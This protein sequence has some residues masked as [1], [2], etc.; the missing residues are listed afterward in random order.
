MPGGRNPRCNLSSPSGVWNGGEVEGRHATVEELGVLYEQC[1]DR[2]AGQLYAFT[3]DWQGSL[4]LV[5]EA[6]VRTWE[7]WDRVGGYDNPEAFVRRVAFN[8]AK[9]HWRRFRRTVLQSSTPEREGPVTDPESHHDLVAAL[10][11]LP[12]KER[13]AVVLHYLA[14]EPVGQ[15][16]GEMGVPEGTVKSWLSRARA[17]LAERLAA[18]DTEEMTRHG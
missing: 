18:G 1:R 6:F 3:G 4:D 10:K 7:R 17:R 16:A 8:L 2:L 9:S 13:E 15:I 11:A 14:G 12:Q 5:Q